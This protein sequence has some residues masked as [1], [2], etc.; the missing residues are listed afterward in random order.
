MLPPYRCKEADD[1]ERW[2]LT[3][4][5]HVMK[6]KVDCPTLVQMAMQHIQTAC[7]T[8][9]SERHGMAAQCRLYSL[10][11]RACH[12]WHNDIHSQTMAAAGQEAVPNSH[13]LLFW[14]LGRGKDLIFDMSRTLLFY[15][16][17]WITMFIIRFGNFALQASFCV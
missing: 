2:D 14:R 17:I 11:T 10:G 6:H 5:W 13:E 3:S 16:C 9:Q 12:R 8:A 1:L 4:K 7:R 15:V